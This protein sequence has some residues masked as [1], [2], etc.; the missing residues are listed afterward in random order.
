MPMQFCRK[1]MLFF[2]VLWINSCVV[3][4]CCYK[5]T[6]CLWDFHAKMYTTIDSRCLVLWRMKLGHYHGTQL[7]TPL[8]WP[9][10][11]PQCIGQCGQWAVTQL[12]SWVD[13]GTLITVTRSCANADWT[14]LR[15]W[16]D[17]HPSQGSTSLHSSFT[18]MGWYPCNHS[19]RQK[20]RD[21][22][23]PYGEDRIP[24]RSVVLTQYRIVT[25]GRT[26]LP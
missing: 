8:N 2:K 23:L 3:L 26:D 15:V 9:A 13:S 20:A 22:G 11:W 19:W 1:R 5:V 17:V 25:D 7:P 21:T 16:N 24:L 18:C 10:E 4:E 14:T 6:L 12:V